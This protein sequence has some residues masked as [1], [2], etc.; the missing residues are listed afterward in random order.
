[1][2]ALIS[3]LASCP[4][5]LLAPK[6]SLETGVPHPLDLLESDI[7]AHFKG[8]LSEH[9]D[10]VGSLGFGSEGLPA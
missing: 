9:R 7:E 4:L 2:L 5:F 6:S 1:M 8:K 3:G 10:E